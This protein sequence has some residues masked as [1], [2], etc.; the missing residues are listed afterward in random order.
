MERS[1]KE[2]KELA[3]DTTAA[4]VEVEVKVEDDQ[5]PRVARRTRPDDDSLPII[6]LYE[7]PEYV[8]RI[9]QWI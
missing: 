9:L 3:T 7:D 1:T 2:A 4:E 6:H 5:H 8:E